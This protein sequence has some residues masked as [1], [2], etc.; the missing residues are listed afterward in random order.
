VSSGPR[1]R[2]DL[3]T[4]LMA[5]AAHRR[6]VTTGALHLNTLKKEVDSMNYILR[7]NSMLPLSFHEYS[8]FSKFVYGILLFSL[9][10]SS[11]SLLSSSCH[12]PAVVEL[13]LKHM[14]S[15]ATRAAAAAAA[16]GGES[17]FAP[18]QSWPLL[19][20]GDAI[21]GRGHCTNSSSD[22]ISSPIHHTQGASAVSTAFVTSGHDINYQNPNGGTALH[23]AA[24]SG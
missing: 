17:L 11:L 8:K 4:P 3:H 7:A 6:Y 12:R 9:P 19:P 5:A 14:R 16:T 20:F 10:T 15:Q 13:L 23:Y 18:S 22:L 24:A 2:R 21:E 1:G